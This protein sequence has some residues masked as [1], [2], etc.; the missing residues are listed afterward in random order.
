MTNAHAGSD[1]GKVK[2]IHIYKDFDVYNGLLETFM[3]MAEKFAGSRYDFKVCVFNHHDG[4]H[5]RRF[6]ELGGTLDSLGAGWE[7]DPA[8]IGRLAG[9]LKREQ[10][11][12]VQTYILK[13]NLYGRIAAKLAGVPV[14]VATELTLKNQAPTLP[15]RLRDLCLH[16]VNDWLNRRS[17]AVI[18]VARA[19]GDQW[20]GSCRDKIR[21]VYPPFDAAKAA[22]CQPRAAA[23]A[24]GGGAP[25]VVGIVAR[26]SEEKRHGDLLRAFSQVA[27]RLPQARLSVVGDGP[28]AGRLQR[29]A[30]SLGIRERVDFAGFQEDVFP[31]LAEMDLFVLP[32]RSEGL[33]ISIMEAMAAGLPVVAS[34]VGGIPELVCEGETGLLVPAG[35][36]DA[37][38]GAMLALLADPPRLRRMGEAGR[39]RVVDSFNPDLFIRAHERIY[40][41]LLAARQSG[42]NAAKGKG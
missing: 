23:R 10:P 11:Q 41:E 4:P 14:L 37:L 12:I 7:D 3:I 20:A 19:I 32:S 40:D 21:I 9:Y 22:A 28:L 29:M 18:C 26:L 5:V 33:S 13:P 1:G 25:R 16:P 17:D 30:A 27:G 34:R 42:G 35:R 38:A 15:R 6:R 39:R 2:V 8:I 24:G 36:P 31:F